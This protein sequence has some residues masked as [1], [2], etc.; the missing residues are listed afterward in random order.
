MHS[1]ICSGTAWGPAWTRLLSR[2]FMAGLALL[3]L[4]QVAAAQSPP[5]E[6]ST[7]L[8]AA[9][10]FFRSPDIREARLSPSGKRLALLMGGAGRREGLF[11]LELDDLQRSRAV[12]RFDDADIRRFEWVN[13]DRLVFDIIDLR[14]GSGDQRRASGL[15]SVRADGSEMR[16][17]V[18]LTNPFFVSGR[19]AGREPLSWNHVLLHVPTGQGAAAEEVIV[20]RLEI[21]SGEVT[22]VTPLRLNVDTGRVTQAY[23]RRPTAQQWLFDGNGQ[24]RLARQRVGGKLRVHWREPGQDEWTL[25]VEHDVLRAPWVPA[26]VEPQGRLLVTRLSPAGFRVL[27]RFDA[28]TRAPAADPF[29]STPGFDFNGQLIADDVSG[30]L[31]GVRVNTDAETTVWFD[32]GMKRVQALADARTPG[33]I[34]RLSCSRCSEAERVVLVKSY[35]ARDP[36]RYAVFREAKN[37]WVTIGPVRADIEP[38]R[39]A[40]VDFQRI[41]ARDG[42]D[43]PLWLTV[44][45]G[46]KPAKDGAAGPAIVL[47]HG[48]PWMRGGQWEWDGLE[49]FLASR[50]YV[51]IQPEFR[52]STGYGQAHFRAG[53]RQWGRAMQDDVADAL[54]WAVQQGWA[55]PRRVCIIGASYGGYGALMGL[56]RHPELYRCAAAWVAVTDPRLLFEPLWRSDL[57]DDVRQHELPAMIGDPVKDAAMLAEVSPVVQAARIQAP[58]LL[59]F[60]EDDRRVPLEHGRDLRAAMQKA[61]LQPEWVTYPGEGHYWL[62]DRTRV[63]FARRLEAFL[64]RH[65]AP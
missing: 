55:D 12:A 59:A 31:I 2:V 61:G 52:G 49:Q 45:P 64:A 35:A 42:R 57:S 63:D 9:E 16:L 4:A 6:A 19:A 26:F 7:G 46:R 36:G 41:K 29:V 8:Q 60:G 37:E 65:L 10:S 50:G 43:L 27:H 3:C 47:V 23:E 62:Q 18:Q 54:Q 56:V 39:M 11:V 17:L 14:A 22:S 44:P 33:R 38:R 13:E 40:E 5:A 51:V 30:R 21:G 34:N 1:L 48:G 20:G 28:A 53:W 24:A 58:L 32:E 25:L 15:F